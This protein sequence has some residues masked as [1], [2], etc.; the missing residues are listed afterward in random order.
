MLALLMT[1]A[2]AF[3]QYEVKLDPNTAKRR[4]VPIDPG[5]CFAT[6][7]LYTETPW[8][9]RD[10][11]IA[12]QAD[13]GLWVGPEEGDTE[14]TYRMARS[15]HSSLEF[16]QVEG[17]LFQQTGPGNDP[18]PWFRATV[19]AVDVD[20]E[21]YSAKS[22]EEGEDDRR[23]VL[24][25]TTNKTLH[26]IVL[27]QAPK[28]DCQLVRPDFKIEWMPAGNVFRVWEGETLWQSGRVIN[29]QQVQSWP[30][31]LRIEPLE[32]TSDLVVKLTGEADEKGGKSVD[33][34]R[35]CIAN[36]DLD[37]DANN[38]GAIG[39]ADDPLEEEPGGILATGALKRINLKFEPT[40]LTGK[41][42]FSVESGGD[43]V[44]VWEDPFK[45]TPVTSPKEWTLSGTSV[46][47]PPA[48]Y[49]EGVAASS[50]PRDVLLRLRY[51][52]LD[53]SSYCDD[54]VRLTVLKIDSVELVGAPSD[55]LVVEK[56]DDVTMQANILPNTYVPPANEPK[57]YYQ[58]LKSD[59]S[60]E[61]WA[62]FGTDA[63][64][65]T[66]THTTTVG[67]VFRVKT[68]LT[69][70]GSVLCEKIYE[71]TA[72]EVDGYGKAGD[73]DAFGVTDTQIQIS[74]RNAAKGFLGS[75]AYPYGGVVSAQYGFPEYPANT[76][77][78]NI[79]VAHRAEQAGADVPAINGI[80]AEYPPLANEWAG[81]E[82]THPF[83]PGFQT[84]I[85]NWTLLT[86]SYPQPGF[87]V[88]HPSASGPGHVGIVDYD[89][90]GIG[91]GVSGT[92]NKKYPAF[93]D[94]TSGFRRYDP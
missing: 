80:P 48:L 36:V 84:D 71:R 8:K 21:E 93:L 56:E 57:W 67:G 82:D 50:S 88:G 69:V 25:L 4:A 75:T 72:D 32:A 83:I 5:P 54:F 7:R 70:D 35:G 94:G 29:P 62:S 51:T 26:K 74:I 61:A 39:E 38:D 13:D 12:L 27:V 20:W 47:V 76:Y 1:G 79:F 18:L 86:T 10:S 64:G 37:V 14:H 41:L 91:A 90:H 45:E 3:A 46:S 43:K 59:G 6:L 89:G 68:V 28:D 11:H 42:T 87:I 2:Q 81:T 85:D 60:W 9:I 23:A 19:P 63:H 22:Y 17:H 33:A 55:G 30:I 52:N 78:C 44:R 15:G 31:R 58:R 53:G 77:K 16:V 24:P 65:K 34:I 40:W 92:V 49:A 73:P 66:Y